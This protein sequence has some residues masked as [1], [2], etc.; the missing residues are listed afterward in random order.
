V[1]HTADFLASKVEYDMWKKSGGSTTPKVNKA[2]S[3]T[4]KKINSSEGLTSLL[5]NL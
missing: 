4:G 5:K 2:E 1:L 3:S